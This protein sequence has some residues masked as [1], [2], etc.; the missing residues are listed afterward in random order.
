M[1]VCQ[2]HQN[3]QFLVAAFSSWCQLSGPAL[4]SWLYVIV[5]YNTIQCDMTWVSWQEYLEYLDDTI[6]YKQ[7]VHTDRKILIWLKS[8]AIDFIDIMCELFKN[9]T[10]HN[11]IAKSVSVHSGGLLLLQWTIWGKGRNGVIHWYSL[12]V[13]KGEIIIIM[14]MFDEKFKLPHVWVYKKIF[15]DVLFLKRLVINWLSA[16][17]DAAQQ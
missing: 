9:L 14:K 17:P 13:H 10:Q 16:T 15:C 1:C 4:Q 8:T 7:W 11:F 6:T 2:Y 5:C 3:A 12:L